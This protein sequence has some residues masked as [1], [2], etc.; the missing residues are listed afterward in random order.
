MDDKKINKKLLAICI[1][2]PLVV[3][4]ISALLTK[5]SMMIFQTVNKP[6]LSPPGWLFPLVWTILYILMGVA[7]YLVLTSEGTMEEKSQAI[8]V[9]F[10][11]LLV[12]FLWS[13]WFFNLQWYVFAFF[14][15]ILLWVL[16]FVTLVRFYRLSKPAGYLMVP[17][18]LWV[19]FAGYLNLG[20]ALLN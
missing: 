19:T 18:L 12:N 1:A 16:I 13:T 2:I 9:Y 8:S 4:A 10:Y 20:I 5:D 3:G 7:S 14:W 15:L 11:Q 17:Y 6:P